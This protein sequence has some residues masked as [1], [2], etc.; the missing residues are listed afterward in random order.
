MIIWGKIIGVLLGF[1]LGHNS[2]LGAF[3]GLIVGHWVDLQ[4]MRRR[5]SGDEFDIWTLINPKKQKKQAFTVAVV[6]LAAK[7]AKC[8]GQVNRKEVDAFKTSFFVPP[9]QTSRIGK[10]FDQAKKNPA[11]Y[12]PLARKLAEILNDSPLVLSEVLK[13]LHIIALSD[14]PLQP[15]EKTFL[16][17]VALIFGLSGRIFDDMNAA[18]TSSEPDPYQV[19]GVERSASMADIKIVWRKLT[20]EHH[21]DAM[22]ARGVP[23][24]VVDQ[25]TRQMAAINAAYD[26]IRAEKGES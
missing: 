24:D 2:A 25:A 26:R 16:D 23:K 13:L 11:D 18:S 4:I 8:D 20:R 9:D 12:E 6:S 14:G 7:L 22:I 19:L 17:K 1:V 5:A 15:A 10:I 3:V 21:P